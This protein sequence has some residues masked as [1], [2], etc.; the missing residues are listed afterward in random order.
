MSRTKIGFVTGTR[1]EIIKLAPLFHALSERHID[2]TW[3]HSGQ[4]DDLAAQAF[5]QFDI[6]PDVILEQPSN[7][8][9]ANLTSSLLNSLAEFLSKSNFN[10]LCVQGDTS[11]ALAGALTG[12]YADIPVIHIEAGL[13]SGDMRN[14]FPEES[15]RRLISQVAIRHY[16]PTETA[17]TALLSEG[18]QNSAILMT[19]NTGIDAQNYLKK[20]FEFKDTKGPIIVTAHRRENWPYME[21]ICDAILRLSKAHPDLSFLFAMHAN[22]QI[23]K[24]LMSKIQSNKKIILSPPIDY[25]SMQEL[26]ANAPL[27]L[28]DSGGIQEEAPTYRVPVV[29]LREKTERPELIDC[30]LARLASPPNIEKIVAMSNELLSEK[31]TL[32]EISNPFGDGKAAK[33]IADDLITHLTKC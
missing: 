31:E 11:T 9:V 19:G 3:C 24:T 12:F 18:I 15:N 5:R 30:G 7:E 20:R 21:S 26:L 6:V 28:T 25:F 1:P 4:H 13:R 23:Q 8:S 14:P 33:Y 17:V 29:I 27:V 2:V 16:A 10:A 22:P 32:R